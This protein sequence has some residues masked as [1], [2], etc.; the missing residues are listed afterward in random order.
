MSSLGM[1]SPPVGLLD[2]L[3]LNGGGTT[4]T[5]C[6]CLW[7]ELVAWGSGFWEGFRRE[8]SLMISLCPSHSFFACFSFIPWDVTAFMAQ[9]EW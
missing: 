6:L 3:G 2:V 1:G 9:S 7:P 4:D 8:K 5:D